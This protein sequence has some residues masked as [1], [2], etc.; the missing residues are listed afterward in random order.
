MFCGFCL[1][2]EFLTTFHEFHLIYMPC[3]R[4]VLEISR[5]ICLESDNESASGIGRGNLK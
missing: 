1:N 3:L 5:L 2:F 4:Y